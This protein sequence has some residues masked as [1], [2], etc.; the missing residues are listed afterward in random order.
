V[1]K[2]DVRNILLVFYHFRHKE[3]CVSD[4][5]KELG[6]SHAIAQD[7]VK[8]LRKLELVEM[9]PRERPDGKL[10]KYYKFHDNLTEESILKILNGITAE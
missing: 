3:F 5:K 10:V 2:Q 1:S 6:Y 8:K 4:L 7:I 9:S